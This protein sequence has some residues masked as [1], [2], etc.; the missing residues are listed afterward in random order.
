MSR[1]GESN[2][3]ADRMNVKKFTV[4]VFLVLS[5]EIL[6]IIFGRYDL[7]ISK[8]LVN[9]SSTWAR[10]LEWL[11][12]FIE[13]ILFT[14]GGVILNVY[15]LRMTSIPCQCIRVIMSLLCIVYGQWNF[16]MIAL[17]F[18]DQRTFVLAIIFI[19]GMCL[20]YLIT[21]KMNK[22]HLCKMKEI[23][24][25]TIVLVV[26]ATTIVNIIKTEWGRTRFRDMVNPDLEFTP[27]YLPQG[28][29]GNRS[30]PS[31]HTTQASMLI[32]ITMFAGICKNNFCKTMCYVL[33]IV[34]ILVMACSR[35]I[36]GAHFCSDVL[37]AM[38]IT[39]TLFYLIKHFVIKYNIE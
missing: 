30:F 33:P 16:T 1:C 5:W 34:S 15:Y 27:W 17:K 12:V 37:F 28:F 25:T 11:G 32:A 2:G 13:S 14:Y 35:V 9:Q 8:A 36:L 18:K 19:I 22:K 24:I 7:A 38:I 21:A 23:A 3:G 6:A 20:L 39:I 31:G 4:L 10:T 29:T 26:I